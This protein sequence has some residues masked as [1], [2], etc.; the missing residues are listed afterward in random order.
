MSSDGRRAVGPPW[1]GQGHSPSALGMLI[2]SGNFSVSEIFCILT[3]FFKRLKKYR[4]ISY[5]FSNTNYRVN[6]QN[7]ISIS[8]AWKKRSRVTFLAE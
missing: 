2:S 8:E 7:L 5:V 4:K 3:M 1:H 6:F